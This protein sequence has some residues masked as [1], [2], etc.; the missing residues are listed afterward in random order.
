MTREELR[1][2][3]P[4]W[5]RDFESFVETGEASEAFLKHLERDASCQ[6]AVDVVF[7]QQAAALEELS[8][9]LRA[10]RGLPWA[11]RREL[12]GTAPHHPRE[13]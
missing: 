11:R 12:P 1:M 6:R 9:D 8:R 5:Q 7:R 2:V 10:E 3:E 4:I 13:R